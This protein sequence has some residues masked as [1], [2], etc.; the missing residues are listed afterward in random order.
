MTDYIRPSQCESCL[1]VETETTAGG[2]G[3]CTYEYA[4]QPDCPNS[5]HKNGVSR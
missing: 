3:R 5:P 1:P 4:H 2:M